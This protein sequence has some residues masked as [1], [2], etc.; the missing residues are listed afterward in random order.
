MQN[1]RGI[2]GFILNLILDQEVYNKDLDNNEGAIAYDIFMRDRAFLIFKGKS[3]KIGSVYYKPSDEKY[4][5]EIDKFDSIKEYKTEK[6]KNPMD[7]LKISFN[8]AF[9][10]ASELIDLE[11]EKIPTHDRKRVKVNLNISECT[12]NAIEYYTKEMNK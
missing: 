1:K 5:I 10:S 9:K 4:S 12:N 6:I 7:I 3:R 11:R 2:L 8:I